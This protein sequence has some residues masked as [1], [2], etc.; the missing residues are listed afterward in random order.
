MGDTPG[1]G[2]T[3][4]E[5]GEGR[6]PCPHNCIRSV[7][8]LNPYPEG[9]SEVQQFVNIP[10]DEAYRGHSDE[11][12]D[13]RGHMIRVRVI[14][15]QSIAEAGEGPF[16]FRIR[17]VPGAV[18]ATYTEAEKGLDHQRYQAR[19]ADQ[20]WAG[21]YTI[22]SGNDMV[23]ED[24]FFVA[25]AG[26]DTYTVQAECSE[27]HSVSSRPIRVWRRVWIQEVKMRDVAAAADLNVFRNKFQN[28]H[29]LALRIHPD[30][31]MDRISNISD[32]NADKRL[33][34]RGVRD[35]YDTVR[36]S[37][38]SRERHV[39]V[40]A[41]TYNLGVKTPN[42]TVNKTG[43]T[44][45]GSE[46]DTAS[47][48]WVD[49]PITEGGSERRYL[50]MGIEEEATDAE[51]FRSWFVSANF[52]TDDGRTIPIPDP[53]TNCRPIANP[54]FTPIRPYASNLVQVNLVGL[55]PRDTMGT[56]VLEVNGVNRFRGGVAYGGGNLICVCTRTYWRDVGTLEQNAIIIHEMGHKIGMVPNGNSSETC[57]LEGGTVQFPDHYIERGHRGN[58]CCAGVGPPTPGPDYSG[59]ESPGC[60]MFGRASS[61]VR[62]FCP[63]CAQAVNKVDLTDGWDL[64]SRR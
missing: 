56:I 27:G 18:N 8:I 43:V 49:V 17:L 20:Q 22:D 15:E 36:S 28:E 4:R 51:R 44:A 61:R 41:Y 55:V 62:D 46:T 50:W 33:F 48:H 11:E 29:H 30:V 26:G 42:M 3:T 52:R 57:D 12:E 5:T 31:T 19:P 9:G 58:H 7:W 37:F 59:S 54:N 63:P 40:I 64:F 23:L 60:V 38:R 6:Q 53:Q 25:A 34:L 45:P 47:E 39:V 16:T 24:V 14:L 10:Q 2:S 13:R 1:T 35:A 32:T 21:P